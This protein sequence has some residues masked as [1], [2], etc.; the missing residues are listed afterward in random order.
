MHNFVDI[1]GTIVN[2]KD[3]KEIKKTIGTKICFD[4]K[5]GQYKEHCPCLEIVVHTKTSIT[6]YYKYFNNRLQRWWFC[7]K[8]F[9]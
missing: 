6:T 8:Y 4:L 9:K 1:D 5:G 7:K 3:I 2:L